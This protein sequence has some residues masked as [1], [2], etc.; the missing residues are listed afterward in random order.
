[1]RR[2]GGVVG[3]APTVTVTPLTDILTG[4]TCAL[5]PGTIDWGPGWYLVADNQRVEAGPFLTEL[6]A[7]AVAQ[8][9]DDRALGV[10]PAPYRAR[11]SRTGLLIG[12]RIR[13]RGAL[14]ATG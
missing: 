4:T 2:L 9:L 14:Q 1:M 10:H 13:K 5:V 8:W 3:Y 12:S 11:H 7:Y 6:A